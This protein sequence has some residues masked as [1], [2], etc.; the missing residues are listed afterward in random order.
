MQI[1]NDYTP[2]SNQTY[3]HTNT[4]SH[5]QRMNEQFSEE[6]VPKRTDISGSSITE[7]VSYQQKRQD[8]LELFSVTAQKTREQEGRKKGLL[9]KKFWERLGEDKT[10]V[11]LRQIPITVKEAI[12]SHVQGMIHSAGEA[13][14]S[15]MQHKFVRSIVHFPV[16]IKMELSAAL[17][18]FRGG[19]A[20]AA[21]TD[22]KMPSKQ[23]ANKKQQR[24][25][26]PHSQRETDTKRTETVNSHLMDSYSKKGTYCKI[27]ENL[28]Y[29]KNTVVRPVQRKE[30]QETDRK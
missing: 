20:F 5:T 16:K 14:H 8:T 22:G 15:M 21:L 7:P 11:S 26:T 10:E 30:V 2:Y 17:K 25:Q 6:K 24:R 23:D 9:L 19:E 18:R 28:T 3:E 13:L 1:R 29:Q 27:N 4:Y 12:V